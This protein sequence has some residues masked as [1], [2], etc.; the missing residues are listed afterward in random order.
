MDL[1]EE[2]NKIAKR[3]DSEEKREKYL[4][5]A[6]TTMGLV[7]PFIRALGYDVYDVNEVCP[8]YVATSSDKKDQRVDYAI[9]KDGT[10]IILIE[11]KAL[12]TPLEQG[13]ADQLRKYFGKGNFKAP[14]AILTDGNIYKFYTDLVKENVMDKSPYMTFT[15]LKMSDRLIPEIQK[16]SKESFNPDEAVSAAEKLK[17]TGIFKKFFDENVENP[18]DDLVKFFIKK[19]D[20]GSNVTSKLV[21]KF[22][23]I[24]KDAIN[25]YIIDRI[26]EK[27]S[28][29]LENTKKDEEKRAAEAEEREAAADQ[30]RVV[31]TDIELNGFYIVKAIL[32]SVVPAE[33]I[34]MRDKKTRFLVLFDDNIQKPIVKFYFDDPDHLS[35][36][37]V[38]DDKTGDK[39]E[40]EKLDDLYKFADQM[41]HRALS[42]MNPTSFKA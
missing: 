16:L 22:R 41:K 9:L 10:P 14:V 29:A 25:G 30:D 20:Y 33:K 13:Q 34:A 4:T 2:L 18:Q 8:E 38:N 5:E 40:I 19:S 24:L 12:G 32:A 11:C 39:H 28:Q 15:L 27:F 21:E 37:L 3:I 35:V 26:N 7:V 42:Y 31:T 6:A 36:E 1:K 17:Y 23:P